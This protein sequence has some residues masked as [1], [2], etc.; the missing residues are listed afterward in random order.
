MS[1]LLLKETHCDILFG[2]LLAQQ[3]DLCIAEHTGR[4]AAQATN[5]Q[6]GHGL[7]IE[8]RLR[9]NGRQGRG[10]ATLFALHEYLKA[11]SHRVQINARR[12]KT[13]REAR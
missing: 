13:M 7:L 10:E 12:L 4:A 1:V 2:N 11:Q 9:D 3:Y 8:D 5:D 6:I